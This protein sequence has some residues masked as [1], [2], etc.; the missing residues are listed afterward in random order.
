VQ[1]I[2]PDV[3]QQFT[4]TADHLVIAAGLVPKFTGPTTTK[5]WVFSQS[6]LGGHVV[7]KGSAVTMVPHI[8]PMP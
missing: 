2:V 4:K 7:D 3:T 5:S 8:G 6:P 1:V